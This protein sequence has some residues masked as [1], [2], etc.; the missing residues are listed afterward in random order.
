MSLKNRVK[1]LEGDAR[2]KIDHAA[3]LNA[4][5]R[6]RREQHK[7]RLAAFE[8][9]SDELNLCPGCIEVLKKNNFKQFC[10]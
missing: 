8:K 6:R 5:I 7:Q 9:L 3:I 10:A 1:R 4:G 2:V